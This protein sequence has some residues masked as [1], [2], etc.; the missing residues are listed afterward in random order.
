MPP[1]PS[2]RVASAAPSAAE[3]LS[4]AQLRSRAVLSL[5]YD[6]NDESDSGGKSIGI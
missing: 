4:Q 3:R 1:L 5:E 2:I 6:S